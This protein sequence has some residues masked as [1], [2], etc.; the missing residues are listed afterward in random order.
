V[1]IKELVIQRTNQ[2]F[3]L[4]RAPI[5]QRTHSKSNINRD[6]HPLLK[7]AHEERKLKRGRARKKCCICTGKEVR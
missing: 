4:R 1:K 5:M 6:A 2:L 3:S 7:A